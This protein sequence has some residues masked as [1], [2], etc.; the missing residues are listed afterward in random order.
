MRKIFVIAVREYLA[1]VRTKTFLIG[2][3]LMPIMMGGSIVIQVLLQDK[4]RH[5]AVVDRTGTGL[6]AQIEQLTK[7]YN[8][9]KLPDGEEGEGKKRRILIEKVPPSED[10]ESAIAEQRLELSARIRRGELT[11]FLDIG[12][13]VLTAPPTPALP[14]GKESKLPDRATARLQSNQNIP[15]EFALLAG[16]VLTNAAQKKRLEKLLKHRLPEKD[17]AQITLDDVVEVVAPIQVKLKGLSQR[18]PS[19]GKIEEYTGKDRA[20]PFLVPF[21]LLMLMFMVIFMGAT[22]LMQ[23][24]VEEKIQRIAEVLLGS[25]SPFQLM[26]GKL[27]GLVGVS[28]TMSGVYLVGGYWLAHH[29]GFTRF[30][31]IDLLLWFLV[32][33]ALAALMYGSLFVAVGAACSDIRETQN[34]LLP[35][36][37]LAM[38]PMFVLTKVLT[39]PNGSVSTWMSFFP[40][41]T[42]MLMIA[43]QAIPPGVPLWQPV[44]GILVVLVT[45]LLCVW[46]AGRIFRVGILM[47]GKGAN[48]GQLVRWVVRG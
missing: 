44:A 5:Y 9:I 43:R 8:E 38:A 15:D 30:F 6:D 27:L 48:I 3:L 24:V 37:L 42:P 47:Q 32:F 4:D 45:T 23:G 18:D 29:Y 36:M 34:L 31:P 20:A 7:V 13:E 14:G 19:T 12:P 35:V 2:L 46:I 25:V 26:M 10:S 16:R 21:A 28:L 40:F 22:P 41:A 17:R 11:G 39:E 1:A 33:Q